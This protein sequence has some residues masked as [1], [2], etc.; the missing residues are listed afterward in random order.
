MKMAVHPNRRPGLC[1]GLTLVSSQGHSATHSG[2]FWI[3]KRSRNY[4]Q[5]CEYVLRDADGADNF[6]PLRDFQ[7]SVHDS[8]TTTPLS[9]RYRTFIGALN[10]LK[11]QDNLLKFSAIEVID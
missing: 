4:F 9:V 1:F 11:E 7:T 2:K 5:K 6:K 8:R 3:L 10:C